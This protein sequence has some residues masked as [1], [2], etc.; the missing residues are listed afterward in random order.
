M[1]PLRAYP[2]AP[3]AI[4]AIAMLAGCPQQLPQ[5]VVSPLSGGFA[6][7][8]SV[9]EITISNGG[10]GELVW[11]LEELTRDN[12]NA[13][14]TAADVPWLEPQA[15]S[16]TVTD[17]DTI[18]INANR[19]GLPVG[20][21]ND[22]AVRITAG[23]E[24]VI[25]PVSIFVVPTL[26]VSPGERNL[27][28][29]ASATDF[30]IINNDDQRTAI[31]SLSFLPDPDN[32]TNAAAFDADFSFPDGSTGSL[33]P[34]QSVLVPVQWDSGRGDFG[35]L[36]SSSIGS[37]SLTVSFSP[38]FSG[39]SVQPDPIVLF[40]NSS[41]ATPEDQPATTVN[42]TNTGVLTHQWVLSIEASQGGETPPIS[43][44]A[45]GGT[46]S[47]G[48]TS[49]VQLSVNNPGTILT[50]SG[51]YQL[52]LRVPASDALIIV[53]IEVDLTTLPVIAAS[54][55]PDPNSTRPEVVTLSV[56]DFGQTEFQLDF[57]IAN[58]E[59]AE[60]TAGSVSQNSDLFFRVTHQDQGIGNPVIADVSPAT[61]GANGLDSDFFIPG[62]NLL[63]DGVPVTVTIDRSNLTEDLTVRT[64][65]IEAMDQNFENV[66]DAVAPVHIE[67]RI[68]R[69]PLIIEGAIN[70]SRPPA[71]LR[72]VFLVR[73]RLGRAVATL[74]EED[75][76]RLSFA[77][78]E[79]DL[80]LDLDETS[81]F[82]TG[83]DGLKVNLVLMLDFTG[84][85]YNA[86]V[87][88]PI[89]PLVPG[90]V[91]AQVVESAKNFLDDIPPSYRVA[92]MFYHKR[93]Q[94]E[95]VLHSFSTDRESLKAALDNFSLPA[96][97]YRQSDIFDA[98]IE[99]IGIL[100]AEDAADVLP[101]DEADIRSIVFVTDG[102]DNAS[103]NDAG[104]VV[105]AA[106]DNRVRLYPLGYGDR[107]NSADLISMAS[108][109]GGHLY[110]AGDAANLSRILG[111]EET[112]L[113][114][115]ELRNQIV[116][117]YITPSQVGG[118]YLIRVDYLEDTGETATGS[119]QEDG[120][121]VNGTDIA[122][123]I[124]MSTTGL[125]A[126]T[127]EEQA[128]AEIYVRTD[129]V[130]A[131]VTFARMRFFLEAASGEGIPINAGDVFAANAQFQVEIAEGG[132][133]SQGGTGAGWS[134]LQEGDGIYILLTTEDN[135]LPHGSFGNLLKIT[136][137]GLQDYLDLY[138]GSTLSPE[139]FVGMRVDNVALVRPASGGTPSQTKYFLYPG[140]LTNPGRLLKVSS[141][142]DL[143]PP[144]DDLINLAF[145]GI[146]P[147]SE[148]AWD[149]DE[150]GIP[151]FSDP[152][153][154]D[155][156]R[157]AALAAPNPFQVEFRVGDLNIVPQPITILNNRLD[158]FS[159]DDVAVVIPAEDNTWITAVSFGESQS[160]EPE[161]PLAPG[162]STTLNLHIDVTGMPADFYQAR[163]TI[164]TDNVG[165]EVI[166]VTLVLND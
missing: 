6:A 143:A 59:F 62:T 148:F 139:F 164:I 138:A 101:F 107:V 23:T 58:I 66:I 2:W 89:A 9:L 17:V 135:P 81:Q 76:E 153:P 94:P 152:F 64:I 150:D 32:T 26:Q 151:D 15:T 97:E 140:G 147:E 133:L 75:R 109:T 165:Q 163:V 141:L 104:T 128:R 122:G 28:E 40:V 102:R 146:D 136:V 56:L 55:A 44:S 54:Q 30:R 145:P 125:I 35:I 67:V 41:A 114:W 154:D 52:E 98:L 72:F 39:L 84:S 47:S 21:T 73:D 157:P 116:L 92:L 132:L 80:P 87:D 100:A 74:T 142:S 115:S 88:D 69:P 134:L 83:P 99:A 33:S 8:E 53:P 25:I 68:E 71:V 57:W 108:E 112:G 70:R 123:Q 95:R 1:T 144:A 79:N 65:T 12:A 43:V 119:F 162:E 90:E 137:T 93:Q 48:E 85:M 160:P 45:A 37:D 18:R 161:G 13:P 149:R 36:V 130:P 103:V 14:W 91:L 61:G 3:V 126:A 129:Y 24:S 19:A 78:T 166:S 49:A 4:L 127:F 156:D 42:I 77:I 50:G 27:L 121:F 63:I 51:N 96:T 29:G 16:G 158:S 110:S 38:P 111:D 82:V 34:G 159:I 124:S 11:T 7:N 10:D 105:D 155:E 22:G 60:N 31:W 113:L 20:L 117:T 118:D 120:I 5:L 131:G 106:R 86:G 46:T